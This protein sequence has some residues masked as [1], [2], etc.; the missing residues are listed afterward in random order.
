MRSN[1]SAAMLRQSGLEQLVVPDNDAYIRE[2]VRLGT[3]RDWREHCRERLTAGTDTLYDD[4]RPIAAL[5]ALL[6]RLC[7]AGRP[8]GVS[9]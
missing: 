8:S 2:A 5:A 3:D 6:E 7:S 4:P 9:P 1:Q